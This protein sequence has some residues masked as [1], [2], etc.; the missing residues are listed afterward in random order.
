[1]W[2]LREN[3]ISLKSF[4]NYDTYEEMIPKVAIGYNFQDS[5]QKYLKLSVDDRKIMKRKGIYQFN[6]TLENLTRL[7]HA[8]GMKAYN[9]SEGPFD[10]KRLEKANGYYRIARDYCRIGVH[11][12]EEIFEKALWINNGIT[13]NNYRI[14]A[15]KVNKRK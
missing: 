12:S 6:Q 13:Y 7:I 3:P 15:D 4:N 2:Q 10:K 14:V 1:M 9:L 11:E 8:Y 5:I